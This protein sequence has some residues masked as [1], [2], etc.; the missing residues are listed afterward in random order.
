MTGEVVAILL[1]G[2]TT[3][4]GALFAG[5][6]LLRTGAHTRQTNFIDDIKEDRD[7]FE[8]NWHQEQRHRRHY[9]REGNRVVAEAARKGVEVSINPPP[10]WVDFNEKKP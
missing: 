3:V 10:D 7:R 2:A 4:I 8:H 6:N 9:E 5:F 1:A